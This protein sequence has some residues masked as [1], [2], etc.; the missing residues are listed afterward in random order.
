[1][2]ILAI[3]I[4]LAAC[5]SSTLPA[6]R[7]ANKPAVTVV[8]DRQDVPVAP[9]K[10]VIHRTLYFY[11]GGFHRRVTRALELPR[12]RRALGVN[13]L[14][15]VP[16][17]TWFTNRIGVREVTLDEMR[18]GPN[19]I[20]N[21]EAHKPWRILSMKT[22]G[23]SVGFVIAD[24]RGVEFLLKLERKGYPEIETGA[25]AVVHKLL[26][27]IGY[28]VPEDY[29]VYA[30]R[31]ELLIAKDA[32]ITDAFG[33]K[34][35]LDRAE[36][37]RKLALCDVGDD[38]RYRA[39]A[40]R[41]IDGT[42]LGGHPQEGVRADDPNDRIS[43]ELR[44]DLRGAYAM[45]AWLDNQDI[46]EAN[47]L[48][49]WV[50]DP[51]DPRRHY[52]RHYMIDF[53]K[54]FGV[55]GTIGRDL[56]RGYE[57]KVDFLEMTR[58]LV[59]GGLAPRAWE[60]REVPMIRGVAIFGTRAYDPGAWKPSTPSYTPFLEADVHDNFWGAKILMRFTPEQLRAAV[61]TARFSDPR[62]IDYVTNTLISR[63]RATALYWFERTSPLDGFAVAGDQLCFDDLTLAYHLAPVAG[64][65][66]YTVTRYDR[67]GAAL[68]DR[69]TFAGTA[70]GHACAALVLAGGA[71]GYTVFEIETARG[72]HAHAIQVHVA[73]DPT[74]NPHVI[75]VWRS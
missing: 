50:A 29:V 11:D 42:V 37:D 69:S 34:H 72:G 41:L 22:E 45:F 25:H 19:V 35:P 33:S 49:V 43:H 32:T 10:R 9:K 60:D 17:S 8:D 68:G 40:S 7:F 55:M 39:L 48:D 4:A 73:R 31:D 24:A 26:W 61:E 57:Y 59:S 28:N 66:V 5:N 54:S 6:V 2:R 21:P 15:E 67:N 44:R 71:A 13:A 23:V 74:G 62:A 14:D 70:D 30:S 38:G 51:A 58:S 36:V 12:H 75:G 53:G 63:Q 65:T 64:E 3:V 18:T 56:R 46:Q 16:D 27:A 20:G 47:T 1:M 52:V